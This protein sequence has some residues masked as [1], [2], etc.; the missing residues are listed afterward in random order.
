[1]FINKSRLSKLKLK[2]TTPGRT[3]AHDAAAKRGN[4]ARAKKGKK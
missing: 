3:P 2:A 1:M 4:A